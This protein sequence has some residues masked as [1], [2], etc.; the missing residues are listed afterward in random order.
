MFLPVTHRLVAA[1]GGHGRSVGRHLDDGHGYVTA[2]AEGDEQPE[3]GEE[4]DDEARARLAGTAHEAAVDGRARRSRPVARLV[5]VLVQ[6]I[7]VP[8]D[9]LLLTDAAHQTG[10]KRFNYNYFISFC[11]T[12]PME[13]EIKKRKWRWIGH[14]LRISTETI[15]RQAITW[16]H[17]GKR[18]RGRPRNT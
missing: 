11:V 3:A 9:V 15:T 17:P 6:L 1:V 13:N 8:D 14:T 5:V 10:N 2:Q 18:R 16:N 7:V 4:S 12:L